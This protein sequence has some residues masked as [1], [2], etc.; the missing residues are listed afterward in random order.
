MVIFWNID[1]AIQA[2]QVGC[3]SNRNSV[4]TTSSYCHG[5]K[6][7][8]Q[9]IKALGKGNAVFMGPCGVATLEF[10]KDLAGSRFTFY[11]PGPRQRGVSNFEIDDVLIAFYPVYQG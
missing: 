5:I 7:P 10:Q 4:I 2:G 8:T 1:N 6:T 9:G 3:Q 11:V